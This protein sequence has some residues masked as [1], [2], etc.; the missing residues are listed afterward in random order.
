MSTCCS[1]HPPAALQSLALPLSQPQAPGLSHMPDGVEETSCWTP[2]IL[3]SP[4][5]APLQ[6][7]ESQS[8]SPTLKAEQR[9]RPLPW[10]GIPAPPSTSTCQFCAWAQFLTF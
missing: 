3:P 5:A 6:Q 1:L 7:I 4:P 8:H 2:G 10:V 9:W